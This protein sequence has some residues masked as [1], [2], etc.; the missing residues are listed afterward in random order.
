[1]VTDLRAA[2]LTLNDL[3][4]VYSVWRTVTLRHLES[5]VLV[6]SIMTCDCDTM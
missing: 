2:R 5:S 3:V 1:M 6:T 4:M